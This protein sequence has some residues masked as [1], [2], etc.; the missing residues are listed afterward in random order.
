[1]CGQL[2]CWPAETL[3]KFGTLRLYTY[4]IWLSALYGKTAIIDAGV[5]QEA[6]AMIPN[7]AKCDNSKVKIS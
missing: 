4:T 1:M 3:V 6:P 5:D 2:I 7:G